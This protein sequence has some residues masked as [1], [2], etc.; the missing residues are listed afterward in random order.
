MPVLVLTQNCVDVL[1]RQL[2]VYNVRYWICL[3]DIVW[4]AHALWFGW[5]C[6]NDRSIGECIKL[7]R[8]L[9]IKLIFHH[10]I[11]ISRNPLRKCFAF[12]WVTINDL[13]FWLVAALASDLLAR[14]WCL[15]PARG[16]FWLIGLP[17]LNIYISIVRIG[18]FLSFLL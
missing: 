11:Y 14:L 18:E 15:Y 12:H 3:C 2:V 10:D 16:C 13:I 4:V 8:W 1:G 9:R 7:I 17:I 5:V 6:Y